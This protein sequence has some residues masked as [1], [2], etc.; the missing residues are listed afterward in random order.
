MMPTTRAASTPS[1]SA[2]RKAE[3][4]ESPLVNDLQLRFKCIAPKLFR[5]PDQLGP[6]SLWRN[7]LS[8][9]LPM[10]TLCQGLSLLLSIL[11]LAAQLPARVPQTSRLE[12][13]TVRPDEHTSELQSRGHLVCRL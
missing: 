12:P 11:L 2:I 8:C 10:R 6:I 13:S 4:T 3:S 5:Q 1:R 7:R 9:R